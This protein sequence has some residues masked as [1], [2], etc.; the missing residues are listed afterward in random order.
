MFNSYFFLSPYSYPS[1]PHLFPWS[2]SQFKSHIQYIWYSTPIFFH[3]IRGTGAKGTGDK[4]TGDRGTGDKGTG[5][6]GTS[7]KGTCDKGTGDKGTCDETTSDEGT[8]EKINRMTLFI[9][10]NIQFNINNF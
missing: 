9:F 6:K 4:G 7:D 2:T 10:R 5:D 1:T 3:R 8:G